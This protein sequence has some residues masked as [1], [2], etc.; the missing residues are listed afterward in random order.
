[1]AVYHEVRYR[2]NNIT[3]GCMRET[4]AQIS[5]ETGGGLAVGP[6]DLSQSMRGR[7]AV[8]EAAQALCRG[9]TLTPSPPSLFQAP[10]I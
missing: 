4:V 3:C 7:G 10:A 1:M 2:M 6:L 8:K 5:Y 9:R